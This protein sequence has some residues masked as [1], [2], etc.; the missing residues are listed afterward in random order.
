[1]SKAA[2]RLLVIFMFTGKLSNRKPQIE[3]AVVHLHVYAHATYA[4]APAM[5]LLRVCRCVFFS[6]TWPIMCRL[7]VM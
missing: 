4:R 3:T 6:F 7:C 5:V 1:M 2:N